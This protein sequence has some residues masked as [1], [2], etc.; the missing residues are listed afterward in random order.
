[1]HYL[2]LPTRNFLSR[3]IVFNEDAKIVHRCVDFL[4]H[5]YSFSFKRGNLRLESTWK[6]FSL[7]NRFWKMQETKSKVLIFFDFLLPSI[8]KKRNLLSPF[9]YWPLKETP[10][11]VSRDRG[12]AIN[13]EAIIY[14]SLG[15]PILSIYSLVCVLVPVWRWT[16]LSINQTLFT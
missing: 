8:V 5:C 9:H 13:W 7:R 10:L 15:S 12:N 2:N 1:M 3:Y 14:Q 4:S 16:A 11:Q 6:G